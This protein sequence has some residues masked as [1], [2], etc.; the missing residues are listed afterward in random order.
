MR[1]SGRYL[2]IAVSAACAGLM[3][4]MPGARADDTRPMAP[5]EPQRRGLP[6]PFDSSPFPGSDYPLGGS[7]LIGG[8]S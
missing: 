7:Q 8:V 4:A 6:A 1:R 2:A 5:A 3:L